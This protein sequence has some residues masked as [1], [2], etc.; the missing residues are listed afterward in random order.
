[1]SFGAANCA[2]D[3]NNHEVTVQEIGA[4]RAEFISSRQSGGDLNINS[5]QS[6][7]T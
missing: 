2:V 7:S 3:N 6:A 5:S 1:M 4:D